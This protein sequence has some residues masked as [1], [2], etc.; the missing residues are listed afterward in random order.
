MEGLFLDWNAFLRT[1]QLIEQLD[2]S[3]T[4]NHENGESLARA[5]LAV[6]EA[7]AVSGGAP[8]GIQFNIAQTLVE[9]MVKLLQMISGNDEDGGVGAEM[10]VRSRE[11][12]AEFRCW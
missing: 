2:L 3:L 6:V 7:T 5:F 1:R 11:A 10:S 12:R 4:D 8:G 9:R